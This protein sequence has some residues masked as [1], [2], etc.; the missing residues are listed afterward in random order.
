[1]SYA[2]R[3]PRARSASVCRSQRKAGLRPRQ[4]RCARRR[5][6]NGILL[7]RAFSLCYF[8]LVAQ[9]LATGAFPPG[10]DADRGAH[11]GPRLP[12]FFRFLGMV[13]NT[14]DIV[15]VT[16][17]PEDLW[18]LKNG[19]ETGGHRVVLSIAG[20][21]PSDADPGVVIVDAVKDL[22]RGRDNCRSV[23]AASPRAP[24]LALVSSETLDAVGPDWEIDSFLCDPV[25]IPEA[26]ARIRVALGSQVMESAG[27]VR[28]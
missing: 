21:G 7:V 16:D 6:G 9:V 20:P 12:G 25:A 11:R 10:N 23:R 4:R 2:S 18:G 13:R 1:M 27:T 24:L 15:I 17:R 5:C 22:T 28:V 19:L 26:L 8:A 14:A 3:A